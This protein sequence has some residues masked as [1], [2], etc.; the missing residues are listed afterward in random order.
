MHKTFV[1]DHVDGAV[2][3]VWV[4]PGARTTAIVGRHGD[5]L[6]V[7]VSAPAEGGKANAAV[8]K[9]LAAA[10]H[11]KVELVRGAAHRKKQ[12]LA[13]GVDPEHTEATL[14]L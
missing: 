1:A 3:T 7:R 6:K 13:L 9:I 8:A 4:V 2:I 5:A 10:L 14:A 12:F 11:T